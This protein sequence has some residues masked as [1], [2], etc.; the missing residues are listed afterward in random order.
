[1]GHEFLCG[2]LAKYW[3]DHKVSVWCTGKVLDRSQGFC[4]VYW[5]SI[6][7]ITRFLCGVL[8]KY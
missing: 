4:V 1:M 2:V 6:G 3:M 8:A 7:W 5:Q